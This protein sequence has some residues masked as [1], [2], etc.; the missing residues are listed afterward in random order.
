MND[1]PSEPFVR[2]GP[3]TA[4]E[5]YQ[6]GVVTA[7]N[8]LKVMCRLGHG[9]IPASEVFGRAP[10]GALIKIP[11]QSSVAFGFIGREF[12]MDEAAL[13]TPES[14]AVAELDLLGEAIIPDGKTEPDFMRG[15]SVYP[16]LGSPVFLASHDDLEHVYHRPTSPGLVIGSLYQD[17]TL[18]AYLMSQEFLCKHSAILGTTGSG[19]SCAVTMILRS[20]LD[21]HPNGHI[22]MLDPHNEYGAAFGSRAEYITT[23]TLQLPYWLLTYEEIVE[24]LCSRDPASRSREAVIIKDAVVEAKREFAGRGGDDVDLSVDTPVPYRLQALIHRINS[25]MG[26]L[27]RPD[28]SLPYLRLLNTLDNLRKD[29]RYAFMFGGI[30]AVRD[31]M[32]EILSRILRIPVNGKPMIIL[33]L[34]AVPSEITNVVVSM[35]CRLVFDFALWSVPSEQIPMLLVC[36]EA[37]RY[38][39]RDPH[40]GFE[41]TRRAISRIAQE[42]RKYGVSLCLVTQ[43]PSEISENILSQCSTVFA[44]RMN[45]DKDQEFVRRTLPDDA[46]GLLKALPALRQQEAIVVG[47]GVTHPMRLRFKNLPPDARPRG[48]SSNFPKAWANDISGNQFLNGVVERWRRQLRV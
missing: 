28:S 15:I 7:V 2:Q 23:A 45:T 44:L 42:G 6:I 14:E 12:V 46:A 1:M 39:P 32:H 26:K 38:I 48:A 10:V 35:L 18:P 8:G 30:A 34:S 9:P 17:P 40:T 11:T 36:E 4:P 33:D 31:N 29:K 5:S 47:E 27:D 3:G 25:Q 24:V 20:L 19:K 41:P 43:R 13:L 21:A 37:H 16:H 22:V